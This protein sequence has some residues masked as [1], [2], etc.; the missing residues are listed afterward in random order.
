[1]PFF[2]RRAV[3]LVTAFYRRKRASKTG[4]PAVLIQDSHAAAY[5]EYC[6]GSCDVKSLVCV[7]LGTGL[8]TGIILD[9]NV[10]HGSLGTAG[11]IGHTPLIPDGRLCGCGQ[12]GCLECYASGKGLDMTARE[13]YGDGAS[14]WTIFKKADEHGF[15]HD[16]KP[17]LFRTKNGST[18]LR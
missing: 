2:A 9:G 11:E 15:A 8:G 17:W 12:K 10:F 5:G 14:A 4:I 18:S 7:T 3:V 13:M 1:M 6:A 16:S